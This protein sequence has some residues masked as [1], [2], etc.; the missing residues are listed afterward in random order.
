MALN[1]EKEKPVTPFIYFA[2]FNRPKIGLVG[3]I[4]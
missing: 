4:T 1:D 2:T 3:F